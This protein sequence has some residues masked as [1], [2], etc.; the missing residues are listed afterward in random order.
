MEI[1]LM[2]EQELLLLTVSKQK[3]VLG[4]WEFKNLGQ[5][6]FYQSVSIVSNVKYCIGISSHRKKL[7]RR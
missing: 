2:V 6:L 3:K 1:K 5:I 7:L 4:L